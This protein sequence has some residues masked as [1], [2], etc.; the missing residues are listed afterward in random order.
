MDRADCAQGVAAKLTGLKEQLKGK[1][2]HNH[3]LEQVRPS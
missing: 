1:L 2:T 3:E